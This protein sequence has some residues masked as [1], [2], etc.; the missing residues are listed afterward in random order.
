MNNKEIKQVNIPES[1][2]QLDEWKAK[3]HKFIEDIYGVK[4]LPYQK[5][6]LNL[7][8]TKENI[9]YYISR[10]R[11]GGVSFTSKFRLAMCVSEAILG[12]KVLICDGS[13]KIAIKD[14][15]KIIELNVPTESDIGYEVKDNIINFNTGGSIELN[16]NK[17]RR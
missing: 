8:N 7:M 1:D 15:I 9:N 17:G 5:L 6:L 13:R 10:A 3:P 16:T 4:L 14:I 11:Q 12:Q 2:T